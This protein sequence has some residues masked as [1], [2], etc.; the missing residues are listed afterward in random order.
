M[1]STLGA[2]TKLRDAPFTETPVP[3][4]Q[5]LV[6]RV[7]IEPVPRSGEEG[8]GPEGTFARGARRTSGVLFTYHGSAAEELFTIDDPIDLIVSYRSGTERRTRT[9]ADV[10]FVGDATVAVPSL[11]TGLPALIGVP[12]RVQIPL[13]DT[14]A[15]HIIDELEGS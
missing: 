1:L 5:T 4:V 6:Y 12:F 15:D 14:L 11:N 2:R 8:E 10:L 13:G 7:G 3:A 9:F